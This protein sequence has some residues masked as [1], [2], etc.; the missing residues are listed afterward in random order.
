MSDVKHARV[1]ANWAHT[2][3]LF[4]GA[5][6][7]EKH[8]STQLCKKKDRNHMRIQA[9]GPKTKGGIQQKKARSL[10]RGTK[11]IDSERELFYRAAGNGAEASRGNHQKK[12]ENS[13]QHKN[14]GEL[15]AR[16]TGGKTRVEGGLP[17]ARWEKGHPEKEKRKQLVQNGPQDLSHPVGDAGGT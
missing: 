8:C 10:P 15:W 3:A 11:D 1:A 14:A 4:W 17:L 2:E 6:A 13:P 7:R 5:V 9:G 16:G 12:R